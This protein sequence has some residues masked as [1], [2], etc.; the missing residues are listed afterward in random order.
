[1]A[2]SPPLITVLIPAYNS[3]RYLDE[4]LASACG[5]T[6]TDI[7]ILVIDDGSKD[8]TADLVRRWMGKD[9]RIHLFQQPNG[10][11]S[12]ARNRGLA[13][14]KG[15]YIAFLDADDL[16]DP[17]KL[18]AQLTVFERADVGLVHTGVMDIDAE[19]QP[20]PPV[21]PWGK[22]EGHVFETLLIANF[23]CC[24]SVM[25]KFE[26]LQPPHARFMVGRLSEDWLL[27]CELST[28]CEFGFVDRPMVRY[29]VHSGGTSRNH[30]TM[31]EAELLCREDFLQLA[32]RLGSPTERHAATAALFRA[33]CHASKFALRQQR[34][35]QAWA[36]WKRALTLMP[37]TAQAFGRLA[38]VFV[39]LCTNVCRHS[40]SATASN[41]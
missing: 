29:R 16:W 12:S 8:G 22:G 2:S 10:G 3:E 35:S 34:R 40:T 23:I 32:H 21:E 17:D 41:T 13:E 18:A 15:R 9:S 33:N 37:P 20:C 25:I 39:K 1:M 6:F 11:V 14:A 26:L 5:Q 28:R 38:S 30:T 27:W 4:T 19:G 31:L 7:E 24:S 36:H